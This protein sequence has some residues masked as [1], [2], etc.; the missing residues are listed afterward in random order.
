MAIKVFDLECAQGHLFEGW[1]SSHDDYDAQQA[2]GLLACPVCAS[3][4]VSKRLSAPH[5]NVGHHAEPRQARAA[6]SA[7]QP[8]PG[9]AAR[10]QAAALQ[11]LRALVRGTENVGERFAQEARRIHEGEAD[12]RPIRGKATPAEREQL[13]ADGIA[14]MALPDIFDDERMQ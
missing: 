7:G 4:Q 13:A 5:L 2:R 9:D 10:L 6:T 14:V 1:F 12:E 3:T 8:A 11:Q